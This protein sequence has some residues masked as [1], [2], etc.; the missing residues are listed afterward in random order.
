MFFIFELLLFTILTYLGVNLYIL[1]EEKFG[2]VYY[3]YISIVFF[4]L[5]I[6]CLIMER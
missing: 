3:E 1:I 6:F 4:Y 2:K 5:F